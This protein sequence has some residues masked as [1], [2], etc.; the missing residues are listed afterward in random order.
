MMEKADLYLDLT[1]A[2]CRDPGRSAQVVA[3]QSRVNALK[4]FRV[5]VPRPRRSKPFSIQVQSV[6]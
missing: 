3:V 2:A 1:A 4:S 6:G 5:L